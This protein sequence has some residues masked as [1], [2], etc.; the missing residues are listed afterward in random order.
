MKKPLLLILLFAVMSLAGSPASTKQRGIGGWIQGGNPGEHFGLDFEWREAKDISIDVYGHFYFSDGDNSLGV[1]VGYY[2]NY[3]LSAVPGEWGRMGLY[4]GPV[5][6]IGWWDD[7]FDSRRWDYGGFAI[8]VGV[9]GGYEWEFPVVPLQLYLE[10]NPV[11]EFHYLWWDD[12]RS[13][14][15][16]DTEWKLP[17]F[18][19]R[20]GIRFWF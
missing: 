19:F 8:R 2:W 3:Y 7:D 13:K 5:G 9:T 17:D 11:G 12:S 10:M 14:G 4:G 18:Y 6:G 20:I 15:H 16:S 1:Y